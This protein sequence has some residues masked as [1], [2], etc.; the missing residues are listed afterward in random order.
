MRAWHLTAQPTTT[1]LITGTTARVAACSARGRCLVRPSLRNRHSKEVHL[2]T[3][4]V[5]PQQSSLDGDPAM[6]QPYEFGVSQSATS[7]EMHPPPI[8]ALPP[9]CLRAA[10]VT[11]RRR[12][13]VSHVIFLHLTPQHHFLSIPAIHQHHVRP[14]KPRQL[15]GLVCNV[16]GDF[17]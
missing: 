7:P 15:I 8:S 12:S 10:T 13:E 14:R 6:L 17:T 16:R 4:V 5:R 11:A 3:Y 2:G 9:D 1:A